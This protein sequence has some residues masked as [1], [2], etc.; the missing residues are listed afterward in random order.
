LEDHEARYCQFKLETPAA[1]SK[2]VEE[3]EHEVAVEAMSKQ[4]KSKQRT[5]RAPSIESEVLTAHKQIE[6]EL[7]HGRTENISI[8]IGGKQLR[9]THLNKVYFPQEGYTKRDLLAYYY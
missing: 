5:N 4:V 6:Q 7:F 1:A 8:E 2:V 3:A 9:L